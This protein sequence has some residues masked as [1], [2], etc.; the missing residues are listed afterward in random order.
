MRAPEA[1]AGHRRHFRCRRRLRRKRKVTASEGE[2]ERESSLLAAERATV[3]VGRGAG[4]Q[5]DS[6]RRLGC[7]SPHDQRTHK[8]PL[9]SLAPVSSL[10]CGSAEEEHDGT[11]QQGRQRLEMKD[12][13]VHRQAAEIM[14]PAPTTLGS[15]LWYHFFFCLGFI[16]FLFWDPVSFTTFS[17]KSSPTSRGHGSD[18]MQS[19]CLI[20]QNRKRFGNSTARLVS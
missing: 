15:L 16:Q 1:L 7:E 17:K 8:G 5:R 6:P 2:G 4:G 9:P 11:P 10:G 20:I 13:E 12:L 18:L 19:I 14:T 3:C